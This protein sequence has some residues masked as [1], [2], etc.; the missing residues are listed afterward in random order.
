[1]FPVWRDVTIDYEWSGLVA[2]TDLKRPISAKFRDTGAMRALV[3]MEMVLQWLIF[4][5]TPLRYGVG[6]DRYALPQG[7]S[8]HSYALLLGGFAAICLRQ[9]M[10]WPKAWIYDRLAR[11]RARSLCLPR[12]L[13]PRLAKPNP[14]G[15]NDRCSR[16]DDA[17][18]NPDVLVLPPKMWT[19]GTLVT[20]G[21]GHKPEA[22]TSSIVFAAISFCASFV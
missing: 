5:C 13:R 11:S 7:V 8:T 17:P 6:S 15:E 12:F 18:N 19:Q 10:R 9:S 2:L 4:R 3:I 20:T 1:M 14:H 22:F 16:S 21:P